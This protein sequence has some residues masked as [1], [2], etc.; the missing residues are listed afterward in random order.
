MKVKCQ[1]SSVKCQNGQILIIAVIF[2]VVILVLATSLFTR[3]AGFLRFG[4]NSILREQA[5]NLA[6]AGIDKAIWQLNETV[7][8][9]TGETDTTFGTTGS[10]TVTVVDKTASLK[11]ITATGY[12][13]NSTNPRAKRTIKADVLISAEQ[14]SFRYAAQVGSGG[15]N[16]K[17]SS[18]INGAVYSNGNI[19]GSGLSVITGDAYAHGTISSPD[20]EIQGTP[21]PGSPEKDM[22][23]LDPEN[24]YAARKSEAEAS[25]V[26][27]WTGGTKTYSSG[28]NYLYQGKYIGNLVVQ[29]TAELVIKTGPIWITGNITVQNTAQI[30]LDESFQ[31]NGAVLIT[32]GKVSTANSGAFVPTNANPKGYILVVTTSTLDDAIKIQNSGVNAV[33]YVLN[34]GADLENTAQVTALVAKKL[35]LENSATLTYDSGLASAQFTTGPGGSWLIKKGTYRFTSSP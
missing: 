25:G 4:S 28:I 20:P 24:W 35:E 23:I 31:S 22:P 1:V 32:D 21:Y 5:T 33:F 34:G 7:G 17:N 27:T 15:V 29:N 9:Y 14:I 13:P 6:E 11:T 30:K 3:T 8:S 10:F 26:T 2:L 19:T 12:I 16:M 18:R